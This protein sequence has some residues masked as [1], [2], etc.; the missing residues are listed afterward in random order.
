M[1]EPEAYHKRRW[2]AAKAAASHR[3]GHGA[4]AVGR[5]AVPVLSA[6]AAYL[7]A[8]GALTVN[9]LAAAVSG[10]VLGAV[11]WGLIVLVYSWVV[12]PG[13]LD[14]TAAADLRSAED[15]RD[16]AREE[17]VTLR[18]TTEAEEARARAR[19]IVDGHLRNGAELRAAEKYAIGWGDQGRE[20]TARH[21]E[22]LRLWQQEVDDSVAQIAPGLHGAYLSQA[23][24]VIELEKVSWGRPP[25]DFGSVVDRTYEAWLDALRWLHERM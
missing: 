24:P 9:A 11:G 20:A 21:L 8:G 1:G 6:I 18:D 19:T 15:E 7:F 10:A 13:E 5:V 2:R 4:T 17:I 23:G 12:A 22:R 3:F 14:A 16:K 25:N